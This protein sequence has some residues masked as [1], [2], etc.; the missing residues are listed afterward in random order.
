MTLP[1]ITASNPKTIP[2]LPTVYADLFVEALH[3]RAAPNQPWP[4]TVHFVPYDYASNTVIPTSDRCDLVIADLRL[5]A[6][7]YPAMVGRCM[8]DLLSI[9]PLLLRE[10][11]LQGALAEGDDVQGELDRVQAQLRGE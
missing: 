7:Q 5:K 1:K 6:A 2:S 8:V 9:L 3:V 11:E 4:L 10:Q